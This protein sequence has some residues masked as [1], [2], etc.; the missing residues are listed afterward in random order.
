MEMTARRD[1]HSTLAEVYYEVVEAG[2]FATSLRADGPTFS[3]VLTDAIESGINNEHLVL[4]V[5]CHL[6]L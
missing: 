1:A 5:G 3:N 2:Y 6:R 4:K